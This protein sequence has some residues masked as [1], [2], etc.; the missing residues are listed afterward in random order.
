MSTQAL[1][2]TLASDGFLPL[3]FRW[4]DRVYR[5]LAVHSVRAQGPERRYR[6]MTSAGFFELAFCAEDG[7]W[8]MRRQPNWLSRT[9]HHWQYGARYPLPAWRRRSGLALA[10][11]QGR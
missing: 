3:T 11:D 4:E 2:V 7:Q 1:Q 10:D 6:V 8:Q 9:L 5:V